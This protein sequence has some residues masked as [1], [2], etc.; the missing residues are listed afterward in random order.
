MIV[1][2]LY[3]KTTYH[4]SKA[5]VIAQAGRILAL[6]TAHPGSIPSTPYGIPNPTRSDP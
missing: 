2:I 5:T 6:Q 4:S 1:N 3:K